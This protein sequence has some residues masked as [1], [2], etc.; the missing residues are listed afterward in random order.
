MSSLEE[1]GAAAV[2]WKEASTAKHQVRAA[3]RK[4]LIAYTD[5]GYEQFYEFG[6]GEDEGIETLAKDFKEKC[7]Q[8]ASARAKLVHRITKYQKSQNGGSNE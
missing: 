1:I 7:K 4:A 2:A 8:C 3:R 5:G 6:S